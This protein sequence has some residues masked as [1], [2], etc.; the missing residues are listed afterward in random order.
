MVRKQYMKCQHDGGC[1][2][3]DSEIRE[4]SIAGYDPEPVFIL[5]DEHAAEFGFCLYCGAFIGGTEDI[6]KTGQRGLCFECFIEIERDLDHTREYEYSDD[7]YYED[8]Y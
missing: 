5:C 8:E 2:N 6:F 1:Q 4:W 3:T 7:D